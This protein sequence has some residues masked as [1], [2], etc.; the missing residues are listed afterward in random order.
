MYLL[1]HRAQHSVVLVAV[2][3]D[4]DTNTNVFILFLTYNTSN[5]ILFTENTNTCFISP[6]MEALCQNLTLHIPREFQK[7]R[8]ECI[9]TFR[10]THIL[11]HGTYNK[12]YNSEILKV[13]ISFTNNRSNS[14]HPH[15][16]QKANAFY[17]IYVFGIKGTEKPRIPSY[18]K[19]TSVNI[20]SPLFQVIQIVKSVQ[21]GIFGRKAHLSS[22]T[23]F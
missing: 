1:Y 12:C 21:P 13:H 4:H 5:Y 18:K 19:C 9:Q 3:R 6:S 8:A 20:I 2:L 14:L 17:K 15:L 23:T 11:T 22:V 10:C 7:E 16:F